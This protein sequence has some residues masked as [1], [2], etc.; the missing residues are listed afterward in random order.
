MQ[1]AFPKLFI[2]FAFCRSIKE[3]FDYGSFFLSKQKKMSGKSN[4]GEIKKN[5][6]HGRKKT[7]IYS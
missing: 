4:S 6:C 2:G 1:H 5:I 3:A 7:K